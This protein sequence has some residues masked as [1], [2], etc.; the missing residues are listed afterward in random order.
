MMNIVRSMHKMAAD[1][2]LRKIVDIL[3]KPEEE[4]EA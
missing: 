2:N 4:R 1:D 3:E